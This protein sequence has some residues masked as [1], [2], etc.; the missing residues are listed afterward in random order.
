MSMTSLRN[1]GMKKGVEHHTHT[2]SLSKQ[3]CYDNTGTDREPTINDITQKKT[4]FG[5]PPFSVTNLFPRPNALLSQI[6]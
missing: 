5:P 3:T 6:A 1:K 2:V 4:S